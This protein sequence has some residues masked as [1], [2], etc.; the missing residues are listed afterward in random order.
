MVVDERE[1]RD[2]S[3]RLKAFLTLKCFAQAHHL[4]QLHGDNDKD[5]NGD[6]HH[7]EDG[8]EDDD[9]RQEKAVWKQIQGL[10]SLRPHAHTPCI[11]SKWS[12]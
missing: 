12:R 8:E 9:Q 4:Q 1:K 10:Q 3:T 11:H 6:G 5:G 7:E 2:D